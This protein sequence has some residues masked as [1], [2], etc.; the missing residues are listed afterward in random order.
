MLPEWTASAVGWVLATVDRCSA[1][2]FSGCQQLRSSSDTGPVTDVV[3]G[4]IAG[5]QII[6]RMETFDLACLLHFMN[7]TGQS[8]EHFATLIRY[9]DGLTQSDSVAA[10]FE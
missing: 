1:R 7:R 8:A 9:Q 5:S 6:V 4:K 2:R 3:R 10:C